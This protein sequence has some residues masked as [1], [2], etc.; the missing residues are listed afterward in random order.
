MCTVGCAQVFNQGLILIAVNWC[1]VF[2]GKVYE[3]AKCLDDSKRFDC[4]KDWDPAGFIDIIEFMRYF[5]KT[6]SQLKKDGKLQLKPAEAIP[7]FK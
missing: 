3:V 2:T 6:P 4:L 1:A 7:G 5:G